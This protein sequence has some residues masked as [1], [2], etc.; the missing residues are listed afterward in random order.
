MV[1]CATARLS[2]FA[3]MVFLVAACQSEVVG[4][5]LRNRRGLL[6]GPDF[7]CYM[8]SLIYTNA[9]VM[10]DEHDET[11]WYVIWALQ[12]IVWAG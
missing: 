8:S 12:G 5:D 9:T 1:R 2:L 3:S 6:G 10:P 4:L 7:D 11:T